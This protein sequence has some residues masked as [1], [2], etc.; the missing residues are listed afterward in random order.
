MRITNSFVWALDFLR[1]GVIFLTFKGFKFLRLGA[2]FC[3]LCRLQIRRFKGYK[4]LGLVVSNS[5]VLGVGFLTLG[6]YKFL[7]FGVRFLTF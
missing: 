3:Y 6:G 5:Y 4:F 2:R 7:R 1:L